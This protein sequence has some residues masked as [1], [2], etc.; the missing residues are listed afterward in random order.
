MPCEAFPPGND[1]EGMVPFEGATSANAFG[2]HIATDPYKWEFC[3]ELDVFRGG[4]GGEAWCGGAG[5]LAIWR[6]L[7]TP[8]RH[9]VHAREGRNPFTGKMQTFDTR[10]S[11]GVRRVMTL[12]ALP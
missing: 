4:D 2:L 9:V 1:H 8:Y 5:I 12:P 6:A 7:G 10:R 11:A 3:A